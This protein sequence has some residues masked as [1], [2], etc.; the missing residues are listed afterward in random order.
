MRD[1]RQKEGKEI[2]KTE[3]NEIRPPGDILPKLALGMFP[4]SQNPIM[5][6][7]I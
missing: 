5:Q 7:R 6:G 2:E 1:P 3:K 4:V